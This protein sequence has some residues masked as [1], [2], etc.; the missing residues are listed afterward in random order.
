MHHAK[1]W[2][3]N[4]PD[5]KFPSKGRVFEAKNAIGG[6][7][8]LIKDGKIK[9]TYKEELIDIMADGKHPDASVPL[10]RYFLNTS[11]QETN[12]L[13]LLLALHAW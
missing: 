6:S 9:N 12:R 10:Q 2:C 7:P 3:V 1:R 4:E 5:A 13:D 8:V 11:V